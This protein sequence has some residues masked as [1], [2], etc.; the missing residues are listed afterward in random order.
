MEVWL[1]YRGKKENYTRYGKTIPKKEKK[2]DLASFFGIKEEQ[3]EQRIKDLSNDKDL[4][5]KKHRGG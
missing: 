1:E 3:C 5:I 2:V 4:F